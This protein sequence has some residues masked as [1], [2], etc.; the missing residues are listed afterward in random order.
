MPKKLQ[1]TY[2]PSNLQTAE[3]ALAHVMSLRQKHMTKREVRY[4]VADAVAI[5][6]ENWVRLMKEHFPNIPAT[7][8]SPTRDVPRIKR[9]IVTPLRDAGV[10][11]S[12]FLRFVFEHWSLIRTTPQFRSFKAYPDAPAIAWVLKFADLYVSAFTEYKTLN[13]TIF[14]EPAKQKQEE[15]QEKKKELVSKVVRVARDEIRKKEAE[16]ARLKA[17]N[18]LLRS[19]KLSV[20]T[21]KAAKP[22][23]LPDWN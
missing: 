7:P 1:R 15:R 23:D 19:K 11:V 16:I 8:V 12:E 3:D 9:S 10:T 21:R 20:K 22:T 6:K 17:E 18:K 13:N 14:E 2:A 5:F 4:T